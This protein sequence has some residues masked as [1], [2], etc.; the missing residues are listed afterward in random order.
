MN[1]GKTRGKEG[2]A[3]THE[4]NF[5]MLHRLLKINESTRGA[6]ASVRCTAKS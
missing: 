3:P 2:E 1:N 5:P 6:D 4:K